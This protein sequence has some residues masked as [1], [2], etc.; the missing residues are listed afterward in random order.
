MMKVVVLEQDVAMRTLIAEW[1]RAGGNQVRELG[2]VD[3]ARAVDEQI[4]LAV[5]DLV[6]LRASAAARVREVRSRFPNAALVGM[7]T[8]LGRSLGPNSPVTRALGLHDFLAK[9]CSREEL[10]R[11]VA[12]GTALT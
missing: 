4:E 1:L 8:E 7:S 3:G 9:P 12:R 5:I 2:S 10:L 6:D 11:A